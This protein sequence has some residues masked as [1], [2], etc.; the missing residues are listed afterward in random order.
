[1]KNIR[2]AALSLTVVLFMTGCAAILQ[3]PGAGRTGTVTFTV[4]VEPGRTLAPSLSQF[5]KIVLS[6]EGSPAVADA[7]VANG[8]AAVDLP[9]GSWKVRAKAYRDAQDTAPAAQSVENVIEF[10]GESVSGDTAFILAPAEDGPGTLEYLVALP[11]GVAL[12]GGSAITIKQ[13]G[14]VPE[15]LAGD[16]FTDGVYAISEAGA[17]ISAKLD[18]GWYTV[19]ILLESEAGDT[20]AYRQNTLILPGLVTKIGFAP[21]AE[22]FLSSEERA[23]LTTLSGAVSFG[24]EE[25]GIDLGALENSGENYSLRIDYPKDTEAL[26]FALG[27]PEAYA[28]TSNSESVTLTDAGEGFASATIEVD[29]ASAAGEDIVFV[30][31]VNEKARQRWILP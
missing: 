4:G 31:A 24:T 28:V 29:T 30:L 19:D 12:G 8:K 26:S 21:G 14:A 13:D 20:A 10:D 3:S 16:G 11:E 18:E 6:F 17:T 23:A 15:S 25:A 5:A 9:V 7:P 27:K 2:Q 1:M 22:D